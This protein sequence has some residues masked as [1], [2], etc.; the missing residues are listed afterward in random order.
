MS[1]LGKKWIIQNQDEGLDTVTK[2]LKNRNLDTEEKQKVFF[3]GGTS[4][5]HDPFLLKDIKCAVDRIR[6]AIDEKEKI[7]VFGDYDVDGITS[8]VIL[9]DFLKK[10]G[11]NVDYVIPNRE[12]DGYGLKD[13][14]IRKFKEDGINLIITVDCGISN[15]EEVKLASELGIDTI[16]TDHHDVPNEL[17]NAFAIIN[18]RQKDCNYPNKDLSGSA[19]SYKL[20]SVLVPYYFDVDLA[21]KY[22]H[23]QL[24]MA[25]LGL[26]ADCMPLTGENRIL[27]KYGLKSLEQTDNLGIK[28]LLESA[29]A[30]SQKITSTTIG[31]YLGPRINAAGRLDTARHAFEL[32]LGDAEKVSTLSKLNTQRQKIVE[33]FVNEAKAMV[34]NL[35]EIPNII[36]VKDNKWNVGTLGLI[37]GKICDY[38]HRPAIAMQERDN[39]YVASC[40]SLNDFDIT[41]FLRKD[42]G[43]LFSAFGGHKLAGGFTLPKENLDNFLKRVEESSKNCIDPNN[44]HDKLE[45]DCEIQS[46]ELTY[47]ISNHIIKLEPFGNGNPEPTLIIKNTKILNIKPVGKNRE[48]LQFP[49]QYG[50]KKIQA[51]AFRFGEHIDKINLE[52]KYDI[53][54]NLETNEWNGWKKLQM[55]VIDLK[56]SN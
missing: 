37:A 52:S 11:A 4:N 15:V 21:N 44:F 3:E 56:Q 29:G 26:V 39:E 23:E 22:L 2:L 9:Y 27:T 43:D 50:D 41:S 14:F 12:K 48:H 24:G 42:A 35:S 51:I 34:D 6:K 18:P 20:V 36:I 53:V 19:V 45:I 25:V 30:N 28:A 10:V 31:F 1:F 46:D 54:F 16:I 33:E 32:L 5:L 8:T 55:K 49:V 38:F 17:P 40:R 7:M 47:E 13:Y